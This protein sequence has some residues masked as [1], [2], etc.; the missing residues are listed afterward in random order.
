MALVLS[1]VPLEGD[2]QMDVYRV[3]FDL[4]ADG[5]IELLSIRFQY[6]FRGLLN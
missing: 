2:V 6:R 1:Q 4:D 5:T 3:A